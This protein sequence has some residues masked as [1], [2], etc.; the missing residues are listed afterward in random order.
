MEFVCHKNAF[1]HIFILQPARDISTKKKSKSYFP[2]NTCRK[3]IITAGNTV[4]SALCRGR[5]QR[6]QHKTMWGVAVPGKWWMWPNRPWYSLF[7]RSAQFEIKQW[8]KG[9]KITYSP[10]RVD[11]KRQNSGRESHPLRLGFSGQLREL[12][13]SLFYMCWPVIPALHSLVP[14]PPPPRNS[15]RQ[16]LQKAKLLRLHWIPGPT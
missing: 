6:S 8:T 7:S 3:F 5:S 4:S 16:N 13:C 14:P 15:T 2:M 12:C 1:K 9:L 10:C 11:N